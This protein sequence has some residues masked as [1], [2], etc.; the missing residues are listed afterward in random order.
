MGQVEQEEGLT[1]THAYVRVYM[2]APLKQ[3]KSPS[4]LFFLFDT[5]QI[6]ILGM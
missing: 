3:E 5:S 2:C 6:L 4:R 1:L